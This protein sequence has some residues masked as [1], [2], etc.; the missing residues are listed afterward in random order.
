[1]CIFRGPR[2]GAEEVLGDSPGLTRPR[3]DRRPQVPRP[4]HAQTTG[5]ARGTAARKSS[6][7]GRASP[8]T[9]THRLC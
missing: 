3:V 6:G 1:M 2:R 7:P 8:Q 4:V 5:P 9:S